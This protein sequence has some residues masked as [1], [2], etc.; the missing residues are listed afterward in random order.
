MS[1]YVPNPTPTGG[2]AVLANYLATELNNIAFSLNEKPDIAFGGLN[3]IAGPVTQQIG[4]VAV[5]YDAFDA[6]RP[7]RPSGVTPDATADTLTV[8]TAGVYLVQFIANLINLP[9]NATF[10]FELFLNGVGTGFEVGVDPSNQTAQ[11]FLIGGGFVDLIRG[12]VLDIRVI[13]DQDFRTLETSTV[14][15]FTTRQSASS[16]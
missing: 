5:V 4:L 1:L 14:S 6:E 7:T 2:D 11:Q 10:V 16:D 12:D 15:F 9:I 8:L 13:A 3:L